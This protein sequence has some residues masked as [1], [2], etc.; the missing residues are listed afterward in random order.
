ML[1]SAVAKV[2]ELI[3][4]DMGSLVDK[5]DKTRERVSIHSLTVLVYILSMLHSG[6]GQKRNSLWVWTQYGISISGR[7]LL[8]H[9]YAEQR[10]RAG[11]PVNSD[12]F[13]TGLFCQIHSVRNEHAGA[14]KRP[15]FRFHRP[16]NRPGRTCTTI[17]PHNVRF[18]KKSTAPEPN[19]AFLEVPTKVKLRALKS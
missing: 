1:D 19:P 4:M 12:F 15:W 3:A 13:F 6:N 10:K 14:D 11:I 18:L 7:K 9:R 8:V 2:N 16:R 17:H 5:G